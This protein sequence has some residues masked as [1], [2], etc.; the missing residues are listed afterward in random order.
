MY[1]EGGKGVGGGCRKQVQGNS[2]LKRMCNNKMFEQQLR[3]ESW[4]RG[5]ELSISCFILKGK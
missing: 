5:R 4:L 3:I 1:I 2:K